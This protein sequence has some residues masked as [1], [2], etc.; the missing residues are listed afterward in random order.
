MFILRE[1]NLLAELPIRKLQLMPYAATD[2]QPL[3]GVAS[4]WGP[5]H[6]GANEAVP[7][8]NSYV[9]TSERSTFPQSGI[10]VNTKVR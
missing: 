3:S 9:M 4:L 2:L 8:Q 1:T 7:L 10:K 6:G 5:A